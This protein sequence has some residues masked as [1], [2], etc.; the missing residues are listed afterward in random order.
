MKCCISCKY[1]KLDRS[2][3]F[4][5]PEPEKNSNKKFFIIMRVGTIVYFME[6]FNHKIF[7]C[8]ATENFHLLKCIKISTFSFT[9][10]S[11]Q[12]N[13]TAQQIE[14]LHPH[15]I[16]STFRLLFTHK[17]KIY[18]ETHENTTLKLNKNIFKQIKYTSTKKYLLSILFI[19]LFY[20]PQLILI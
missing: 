17:I 3:E 4:I 16:K 6:G 12:M 10:Y 8:F 5:K 15:T 20:V 13:I 19:T 1:P 14:K 9:C 7:W 11:R 18:S 2:G